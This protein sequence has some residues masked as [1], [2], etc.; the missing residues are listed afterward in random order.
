M[1]YEQFF[2]LLRKAG[3]T[4]IV[5]VR[6][7]PYSRHVPHFNRDTL[8]TELQQDG[9]EYR[10]MGQ[11]LGGRPLDKR[12]FREGVADYE[13]M[14]RTQE[15]ERGLEIVIKGSGKHRLALMCSERDPLDCHRCLL[16]GRALNGRGIAVKHVESS[17]DILSNEEVEER[18]LR[19]EGQAGDD[20]FLSRNERLA[21]AYQKRARKVAYSETI[22][23]PIGQIAAE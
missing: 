18:L 7:A 9:I 6:S 11:K 12:L 3:V 23:P 13:K 22:E 10:F 19:L 21:R 8:Q 5:D 17:G 14:A 2:Q 20:L 15:F 4:A 16:V 1:S